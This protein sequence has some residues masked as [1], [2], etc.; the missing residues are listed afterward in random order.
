MAE[1]TAVLPMSLQGFAR[2][3]AQQ[4]LTTLGILA[5]ALAVVVAVWTWSKTP[6]YVVL[7][8]NLS[9]KDGGAIIASLQQQNV[10]HRYSEGGGAILVPDNMVHDA[11]LTLASQGLPRGGAVGFELM[12][13]QKIGI[14]QFAEQLNYQRGLEGE[15]ARSIQSLGAVQGARVHLAIPKQ[16]GFLRDEQKPS[17]SVLIQLNPGRSLEAAQVAGIVHLVAASVPQLATGAVSVV[18]QNGQ[19]LSN[20][21]DMQKNGLD[22]SQLKY[23]QELEKAYVRRIENILS[24]ITGPGNVR[25]QVSADIDFSVNEQTAEIFKPNQAPEAIALRS[26]QL[27]ESASRDPNQAGVP[28]ALSNQ[29]PVPATAPITTPAAPGTPGATTLAAER[30]INSRRESTINYEVDKTIKHTRQ[31]AGAVKRLSVAV[32]INHRRQPGAEGAATSKPYSDAELKQ[33]SDLVREAM[34]YNQDRG[35]TLN[36]A[37]SPFNAPEPEVIPEVPLWKNPQIIS[38]A[39]EAGRY[40]L[41]GAIAA[42]AF[43]G[44][45]KPTLRGLSERAQAAMDAAAAREQA[46]QEALS[47]PAGPS[48]TALGYDQRLAAARD[49][50]K[51]DPKQV[52]S[53]IKEWVG[54]PQ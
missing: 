44:V 40:L 53:V 24:P 7:F 16:T 47:A 42:W 25:A 13:S 29:P 3:P 6:S 43:F 23:V 39:K 34:G 38:L 54:S 18:D 14:S 10:P 26:Q 15:L 41:F 12:D 20:A 35:D 21:G 46:A 49:L 2:L 27:A 28:G 8:S 4:K 1:Q 45:I 9:D 32:V 36:I 37:N 52:A 17:A 51:Q 30:G 48:P 5:L 50:A 33:I 11:R 31:A 19:L 22:P